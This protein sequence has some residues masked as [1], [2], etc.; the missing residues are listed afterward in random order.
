[1]TTA[2]ERSRVTPAHTTG[3]QLTAANQSIQI[4]GDSFSY[5]RFG[6]E[7]TDAPPLI[8]LQHFRGNLDSWDPLLVDGLA[9]DREVVLVDNRGYASIGCAP[10]IMRP[11]TKR[12]GVEVMPRRPPA[13]S[14][15]C[16]RAS[17]FELS[18]H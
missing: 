4:D 18:R 2:D 1:M 13:P 12:V 8:C 10:L 7:Q 6:N 16:T 9:R 3:S 14:A 11:L 15:S 5:R 17:Y